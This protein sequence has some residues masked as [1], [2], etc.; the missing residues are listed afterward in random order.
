MLAASLKHKIEIE[1]RTTSKNTLGGVTETW[2]LLGERRA[3]VKHTGG[4]K[5][6]EVELSESINDF[7]IIFQFRYIDGLDYDCRIKLDDG[8]YQI[9]DIEKLRRR[10]GFRCVTNRR[11]NV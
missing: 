5:T 1:K 8:I 7:N 2:S 10:E 4:N 6:F 3:S 11:A 9:M